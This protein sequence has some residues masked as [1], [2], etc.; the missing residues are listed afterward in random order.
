TR[1]SRDWSSDVCSSDLSSAITIA[2]ELISSTNVLTLVSG[3]FRISVEYGPTTLSCLYT[4]Y[5]EMNEPKNS[6]SEPMNTQNPSF[7]VFS[8]SEESRV[9]KEASNRR[10]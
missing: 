3:M 7:H 8:R 1:F 9:G 6:V 10:R 2:S 5:A 4:M